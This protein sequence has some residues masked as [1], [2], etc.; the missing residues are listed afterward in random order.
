[1]TRVTMKVI[2]TLI[3]TVAEVENKGA[4]VET[5]R[6]DSI[7][8]DSKQLQSSSPSVISTHLI[9]SGSVLQTPVLV[10]VMVLGPVSESPLSHW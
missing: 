7:Y 10:Q 3:A 9:S 2:T 4:A 6:W 1:M 8:I 5:V